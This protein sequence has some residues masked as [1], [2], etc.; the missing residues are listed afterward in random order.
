[1]PGKAKWTFMVYMAADNNL[2]PAGDKDLE[3][4]RQVGSTPEV[5]IVAQFDNAGDRGTQRYRL[6]SGG[7]PDLVM[8]MGET[9]SGD[10]RV[11]QAFIEWAAATYPAERYALVLWS[12]GSAWEPS[13][14]EKIARSVN[15]PNFS[16]IEATRRSFSDRSKVLF[17]TSLERIYQ[18][19]TSSARAICVDD[20]SGHSLDTLELE[21]VLAAAR[22]ALGQ[23]IDLLGMDACLMSNLEVAYQVRP[24]V[25]CLVASEETEPND[26]WPYDRVL[27]RLVDQP[28]MPTALA[29]EHIVGDYIQSY[30]D[31]NYKKAVTQSALDLE[32]MDDLIPPLDGL[33]QALAA[34]DRQDMRNCLWGALYATTRFYNETLVDIPHLC[35]ELEKQP[36]SQAVR[37][38]CAAVRQA[39][40]Q[41]AG[42]FVL[43]EKHSGK[44][45]ENC[46]GVSIYLP[47]FKDMS[48][49]YPELAFA[50]QRPW[51]KVVQKYQVGWQGNG[52]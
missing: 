24:Y 42:R 31:R 4:M 50:S 28:D 1:M 32:R 2:S 22:Q 49:F 30:L 35:T 19:P 9:N 41:G 52:N 47:V 34:M 18:L 39:L 20:G 8:S 37:Q 14:I 21:K 12:H 11:L 23:Q 25:K 5:N 29:A 38:A 17:R 26:G 15:S 48:R 27:R 46:G 40:A 6:L 36:V 10:P 33:A 43:A 51:L 45:V 7:Q 44:T 3:E 13:E 16:P